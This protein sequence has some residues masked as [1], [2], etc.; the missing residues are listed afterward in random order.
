MSVCLIRLLFLQTR[1][2]SLSCFVSDFPNRGELVESITT[3]QPTCKKS[4]NDYVILADSTA[5]CCYTFKSFSLK[6]PP[7]AHLF[8]CT[9]PPSEGVVQSPRTLLTFKEPEVAVGDAPTPF[10]ALVFLQ[11]RPVATFSLPRSVRGKNVRWNTTVSR[12]RVLDLNQRE[13]SDFSHKP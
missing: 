5:T 2:S 6:P 3:S 8:Q 1:Q 4:W 13:W 7:Q 11:E 9:L 10:W 12:V